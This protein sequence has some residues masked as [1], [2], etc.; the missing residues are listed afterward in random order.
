MRLTRNIRLDQTG[1]GLRLLRRLL[2]LALAAMVTAQTATTA[3]CQEEV[4]PSSSTQ[5]S[6]VPSDPMKSEVL[7]IRRG[8]F[9]E[10]RLI[11]GEKLR[12]RLG[13]V[14]DAGFMLRTVS[15]N[16]LTDFQVRFEELRSVRPVS[17]PTTSDQAF[18]RN[19][20]R[21]RQIM[22]IVVAGA[23]IALVAVVASQAR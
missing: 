14:L 12:G 6:S 1:S 22:G 7:Q 3:F 19:L 13:D 15:H 11:T 5:E 18:D 20:R 9:I 10:V 4:T 8:S 21:T 2:V 17:N 16:R 23:S